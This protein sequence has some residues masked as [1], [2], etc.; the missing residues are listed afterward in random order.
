M[1]DGVSGQTGSDQQAPPAPG[2]QT[3][4]DV[5]T[6]RHNTAHKQP[7]PSLLWHCRHHFVTTLQTVGT[8]KQVFIAME[9]KLF[10]FAET[11]P[12]TTHS[13]LYRRTDRRITNLQL[14]FSKPR[15]GSTSTVGLRLQN[16]PY[17][18][19]AGLSLSPFRVR[20]WVQI[21]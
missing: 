15:D 10:L 18:C 11:D 7:S 19:N 16:F 8:S 14:A 9:A 5:S 1:T 6:T 12:T 20:S 3:T 21:M 13:H 2:G 4:R 17:D